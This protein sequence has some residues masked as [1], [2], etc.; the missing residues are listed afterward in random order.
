MTTKKLNQNP[1]WADCGRNAAFSFLLT[2]L[3]LL[4]LGPLM[5]GATQDRILSLLGVAADGPESYYLI[6][7]SIAGCSLASIFF[8]GRH[9]PVVRK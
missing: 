6:F 1:L 9:Y 4:L 3:V 2:S 8:L 5:E 7:T